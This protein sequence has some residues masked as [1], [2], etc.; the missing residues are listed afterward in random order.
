MNKIE[1]IQL[2]NEGK[3]LTHQLFSEDE[4][5]K[6]SSEEGVYEFEDGARQ[7]S[8]DFWKLRTDRT[9]FNDWKLKD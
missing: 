1:A 2:L 7:T 4:F 3:K 6:M 8:E 5:V 9:W